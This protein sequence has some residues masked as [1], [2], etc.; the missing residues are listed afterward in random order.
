MY[1]T[2][3]IPS[4]TAVFGIV[5]LPNPTV[6]F[7]PVIEKDTVVVAV[8]WFVVIAALDICELVIFPVIVS[9][10][11][12]PLSIL[13]ATAVGNGVREGVGVGDGV[14]VGASLGFDVWVDAEF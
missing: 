9:S 5:I 13:A 2:G 6:P 14:S 12:A 1:M 8:F 4:C 10:T 7:G 3:Y 11:I